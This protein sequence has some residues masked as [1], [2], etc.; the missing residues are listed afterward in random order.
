MPTEV[1]TTQINIIKK[2]LIEV[3]YPPPPPP[4]KNNAS[5]TDLILKHFFKS[6]VPKLRNL[7]IS[8]DGLINH[9][10]H[11][12][13]QAG[14]HWKQCEHNVIYP[15]PTEWGWNISDNTYTPKWGNENIN[16]VIVTCLCKEK[17]NCLGC[18]GGRSKFQCIEY[19]FV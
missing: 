6:P 7:I 17:A 1:P 12:A 14:W 18:K 13:L 15:N 9:I 3:Y 10:K 4:K 2:Y 16:D 8:I 11:A 19:E 5:L